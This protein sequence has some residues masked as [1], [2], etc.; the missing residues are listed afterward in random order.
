MSGQSLTPELSVIVVSFNGPD[1]LRGCLASLERQT[2]QEG[3][4]TYVVG[5]WDVSKD[6]HD[7]LKER[8]P[9]V[10]WIDAPQSYNV[11]QLRK[12]GIG[13]SQGRIVALIEDD[14][15]A[16]ATWCASILESHQGSDAA[17]GGV[18]EPGKYTSMM[19]WAAYFCE[20]SAFMVPG[21]KDS[22][23]ALPGANVSYKRTALT[24][25]L[26]Q[27]QLHGDN[28]VL[29]GFYEAFFHRALWQAGHSLKLEPAL[30]VQN[31]KPWKVSKLLAVRYHHGRGFGGM[32]TAG[33]P[34]VGRLPYVGLA[35]LLPVVQVSR[36]TKQVIAKNRYLGRL[37]LA[38]P[39]VIL[40]SVS[41]SL[42]EFV[43]YLLGP[44]KSLERWR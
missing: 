29:E 34:M 37:V 11:P 4:E 9:S 12:L 28:P 19:D 31:V 18:V 36:I 13:A 30:V 15:L 14:C 42:G 21:P 32:R 8:F 3:V 33:R 16:S 6:E 22:A 25:V 38:F 23:G 20:F 35:M 27:H 41:W 43:G 5:S 26:D 1:L 44:G 17:I 24:E 2:L 40:L 39:W 7:N 10:R